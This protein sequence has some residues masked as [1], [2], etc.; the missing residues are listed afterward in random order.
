MDLLK[1]LENSV[2]RTVA[3]TF[4][5]NTNKSN[6]SNKNAKVIVVNRN[7][8][9]S[10]ESIVVHQTNCIMTGMGSGL[11]R[12]LVNKY[13]YAHT[14]GMRREHGQNPGRAIPQD[15][16][17]PGSLDICRPPNDPRPARHHPFQPVIVGLNGQFA[18][19][20]SI[21]LT[22]AQR[23]AYPAD[24]YIDSHEAREKWFATGLNQLHNFMIA[25][26][27]KSVA[28]PYGIGCGIAGGNWD[29]YYNM[30]QQFARKAGGNYTVTVYKMTDQQMAAE[31]ENQKKIKLQDLEKQKLQTELNRRNMNYQD[32]NDMPNFFKST[33]NDNPN[34]ANNI[35]DETQGFD[36]SE[37]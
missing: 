14:Y 20:P 35:D 28:F 26:G 37:L 29:H 11:Y 21:V 15:I 3:R 19:R 24:E 6:K 7:I 9:D 31:R 18:P 25:Q 36:L 13:P 2:A 27:Y 33:F 22:Q 16:S 4:R 32:P 8:L 34:V 12:S 17:E 1:N 30:L 5:G 23:E 10:I